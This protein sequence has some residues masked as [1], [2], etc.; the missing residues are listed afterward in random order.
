MVD[1]VEFVKDNKN[2]R[3]VKS[4]RPAC[5]NSYYESKGSK[6]LYGWVKE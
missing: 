6:T 5:S 2:E 4:F 3:V 1:W